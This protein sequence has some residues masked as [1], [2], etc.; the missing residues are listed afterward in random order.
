MAEYLIIAKASTI[1]VKAFLT[2]VKTFFCNKLRKTGLDNKE[3]Y[4]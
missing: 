2:M 4:C 1:L 3:R